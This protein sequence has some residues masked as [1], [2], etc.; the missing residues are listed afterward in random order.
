MA[1]MTVNTNPNPMNSNLT[2]TAWGKKNLE[3]SR[4]VLAKMY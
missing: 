1:Y 4:K 2:P 3:N